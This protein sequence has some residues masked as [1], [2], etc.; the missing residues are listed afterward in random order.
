MQPTANIPVLVEEIFR[1]GES[2]NLR[3]VGDGIASKNLPGIHVRDLIAHHVGIIGQ[4]EI[5]DEFVTPPGCKELRVEA[6]AGDYFTGESWLLAKSEGQIGNHTR[7]GTGIY[8]LGHFVWPRL[9]VFHESWF[10]PGRQT[11]RISAFG[12]F[13]SVTY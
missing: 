1:V 12:G 9:R 3:R 2:R 6:V 10:V 7:W 5:E 13:G 4:R 8:F 11:V